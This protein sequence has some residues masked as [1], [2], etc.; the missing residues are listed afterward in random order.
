[1]PG[2]GNTRFHQN[3]QP[4]QVT[5]CDKGVLLQAQLFREAQKSVK[6]EPRSANLGALP[7][8]A[9]VPGGR[10]AWSPP[11]RTRGRRDS[12]TLVLCGP[13]SHTQ[14][15]LAAQ[16]CCH[17]NVPGSARRVSA[18]FP[19][20]PVYVHCAVS[21]FYTGRGFLADRNRVSHY[22]VCFYINLTG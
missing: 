19:A 10:G 16:H 4:P 1:M 17:N 15:H 3:Q 9:A 18:G 2:H 12:L 7:A 6:N 21:H 8:L 11:A 5:G 20:P 14:V 22:L 13:F